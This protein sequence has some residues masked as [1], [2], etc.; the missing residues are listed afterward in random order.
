[1]K[2]RLSMA[3]GLIA[4]LTAIQAIPAMAAGD[5]TDKGTHKKGKGKRGKKKAAD[6]KGET[7][8]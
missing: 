7:T 3:I 1:M 2:L 6:Q 4:A 5:D 8:K